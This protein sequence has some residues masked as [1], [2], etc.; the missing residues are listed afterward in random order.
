M[1]WSLYAINQGGKKVT[2]CAIAPVCGDVADVEGVVCGRDV[3][4]DEAFGLGCEAVGAGE[5]YAED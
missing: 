2:K 4:V 1:E 3:G 5:G